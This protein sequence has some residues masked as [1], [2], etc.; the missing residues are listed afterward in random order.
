MILWERLNL[1]QLFALLHRCST[2]LKF[3]FSTFSI[4]NDFCFNQVQPKNSTIPSPLHLIKVELPDETNWPWGGETIRDSS[5]PND[6]I[7]GKISSIG[8]SPTE[9]N[10]VYALSVIQP[11]RKIGDDVIIEVG[12]S[13]YKGRVC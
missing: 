5:N 10:T 13:K 4:P 12:T 7:I 2:Y 8:Y 3:A 6:D 1:R 9:A 11:E